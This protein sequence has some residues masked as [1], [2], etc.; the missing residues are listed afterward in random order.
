MEIQS[1]HFIKNYFL[2]KLLNTRLYFIRAKSEVTDFL[3]RIK[4]VKKILI[5]LPR[6]RAEEITARKYL[7][8]FRQIFKAARVSTFDI[9]S[10]RSGD[11][12]WLGL[13]NHFFLSKILNENFE[14]IIDLNSSHDTLCSYL[15]ATIQAPLRV[16]LAQG[17]YDKIYNIQIRS[18]EEASLDMR[19]KNFLN[20]LK[21]MRQPAEK[22]L[23]E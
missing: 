19:Y 21:Q 12:N 8:D 3:E 5:I 9:M 4:A 11:V 20:Y 1:P 10:L 13:P 15:T 16:H 22:M 14:L 7:N 6:D 2:E 18:S 17:R 23:V